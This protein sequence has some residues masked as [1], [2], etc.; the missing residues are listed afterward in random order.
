MVV[1]LATGSV[2]VVGVAVSVALPAV[3]VLVV[4]DMS[5]VVDQAVVAVQ[6]VLW[7]L[8]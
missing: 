1:S 6:L 2:V 7:E 8:R 5:P 4:A 3:V